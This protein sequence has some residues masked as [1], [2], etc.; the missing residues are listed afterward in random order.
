MGA[1]ILGKITAHADRASRWSAIA[2]GFS[3]PISVA[4]DSVLSV[5]VLAGWFFSGNYRQKIDAIGR[6]PVAIAALLLYAMLLIGALYG[7]RDPGDTADYLGKYADLLLIPALAFCFR[8]ASDR[9]RAIHAFAASLALTLALSFVLAA[10]WLPDLAFIKGDVANASV[11]KKSLSHNI[12]MSFGAFLFANLALR[13]SSPPWRRIWLGV[14]ILAAVNVLVM[15]QGRTG[16]VILGALSLY[17]GYCWK[18]WR[19]LGA[20]LLAASVFGGVVAATPN[21]ARDRLLLMIE[22]AQ[23]WKPGEPVRTSIGYR[24][25]FYR[26]SVAIIAKHPVAGV[27]TG[28]YPKAYAEQTRGT[29][30]EPS[31]NPHNEY[32]LIGVQ[33]GLIGLALLLHLFWQHWRLAPRLATPLESRLS[34]GLLVTVA[35]GCLFNSLLLD[36]MEGLLFAWMTGLLYGS[37]QSPAGGTVDEK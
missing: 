32:L 15:V 1:G 7:Q 11:F 17:A 30:L 4:L 27:G 21:P 2:L 29:G 37:L 20:T 25:A 24:L 5:V 16:Y 23:S 22:E 28:G 36:H 14:A 35:V 31:R 6:D 9:R 3:I 26:N 18:G 10:G 34:R 13:A 33:T 12:L 8:D 19:G